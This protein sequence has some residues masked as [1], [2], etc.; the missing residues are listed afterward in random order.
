MKRALYDDQIYRI[1][2]RNN[3]NQIFLNFIKIAQKM[4]IPGGTSCLIS[5]DD[6]SWLNSMP[7]IRL[8]IEPHGT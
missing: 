4:T 7:R 1:T 5:E 8:T 6:V 3:Q 2:I